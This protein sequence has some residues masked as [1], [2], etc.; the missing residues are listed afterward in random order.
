MAKKGRKAARRSYGAR[1]TKRGH[2]KKGMFKLVKGIVYAGAL[3][4]P[5]YTAYEQA[6]GGKA[7]VIGTAKAAAFMNQE[8]QFSISSGAQ[9]WAPVAAVAV[10]DFITTKIPIQRAISRGFRNIF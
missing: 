6:G 8:G 2:S 4:A 3:A 10:V 5:L 7:G 1:K 9:I